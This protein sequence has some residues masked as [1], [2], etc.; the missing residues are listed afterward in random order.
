MTQT[1][2]V[3]SKPHPYFL[4][5]SS[6]QSHRPLK[7]SMF[8]MKLIIFPMLPVFGNSTFISKTQADTWDF[9]EMVQ[10]AA[11]SLPAGWVSLPAGWASF[12]S[13]PSEVSLLVDFFSSSYLISL[14]FP[15]FSKPLPLLL[16]TGSH[17]ITLTG[18]WPGTLN[19][20][21]VGVKPIEIL[22]SLPLEYWD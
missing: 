17:C 13:F 1:V 21:Q 16:K 22:L 3:T 5:N 6:V 4:L 11:V 12:A 15:T 10:C 7:L 19:T 9:F 14:V 8:K 2:L 20:D 18:L